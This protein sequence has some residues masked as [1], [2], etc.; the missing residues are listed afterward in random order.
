MESNAIGWLLQ[1]PRRQVFC[2]S[3]QLHKPHPGTFAVWWPITRVKRT[4]C[5][6]STSWRVFTRRCEQPIWTSP[7]DFMNESS[8]KYLTALN[9]VFW[10]GFY[11]VL[12]LRHATLDS[13]QIQYSCVVYLLCCRRDNAQSSYF[14][15]CFNDGDIRVQLERP[16]D[17][18]ARRYWTFANDVLYPASDVW[19]PS[20]RLANCMSDKCGLRDANALELKFWLAHNGHYWPV[21]LLDGSGPSCLVQPESHLY[22]M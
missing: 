13:S 1:K 16:A 21:F 19:A 10:L 22:K 6:T 18:V 11:G 2:R 15:C 20:F 3:D 4:K 12:T 8:L 5:R 7:F 14:L 17:A 9:E